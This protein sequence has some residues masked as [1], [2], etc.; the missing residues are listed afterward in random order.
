MRVLVTGGAGF[1][2]SHIVDMMLEAGYQAVVVDNLSTGKR[3]N[4]NCAAKFYHADITSPELREI[5]REERP[6]YVIHQAAQ[7]DVRASVADPLYDSEVNILGT[8]NLL[9]CCKEQPVKKLIYASS[10][11][12]YGQP[13]YLPIDENHPVHPSSPYGI[14]K[15]TVHH[16]L[17]VYHSLYHVN[18]TILCYANVYGPRQNSSGEA[19]VV[20]IF[21]NTLLNGKSPV[22][23]GDGE[24]TRDFVFVE[25]VAL[26]NF[27][28]L[29]K[30]DNELIQVGSNKSVTINCLLESIERLSGNTV[31]RPEYKLERPGEIRHS[32]LNNYKAKEIL[33]WEPKVFLEEGLT[34]TLA[35]YDIQRRKNS[36]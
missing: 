24:Q 31:I 22:V 15:H 9:E 34:R 10:A 16:F 8:I 23:Y 11:A 35:Y 6:D 13:V 7:V 30:G 20:S 36:A 26:A 18:Y 4:G 19:G 21:C 5:F 32:Q 1:I 14:S 17:E 29:S 25:D 3:E 27:L 33:G 2:G 12:I 28:A